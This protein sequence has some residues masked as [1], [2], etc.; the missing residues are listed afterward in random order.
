MH[1][2]IGQEAISVGV[3]AALQPEDVVFGTYRCHALYLAKGGDL[4]KMIAELYGKATGCAKGKAGSMHLIDTSAGVMGASAVV[5]TTIPLAVGHAF[6]QKLQRKP[7]VTV[8]FLG[9]GAVEEGVFHESLNFAALKKVPILFVCE[10]NSYA[11]HSR[12]RDRQARGDICALAQAHGIATER[13]EAMDVQ[14]IHARTLRTIEELRSGRSGPRFFECCCYRWRE[15]VGPGVDFQAGYRNR[16]ECESWQETDSLRTLAPLIAP[17]E[18]RRIERDIDN[19]IQSAF[20]F[21]EASP[22]PD[23]AELLTDLY[24]GDVWNG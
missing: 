8:C 15:H 23:D 4:K 14:H 5:A 9:D 13:F 18:R 12:Q 22:F 19:E 16:D 21:A 7:T 20:E 17:T 10:N 3:C 2:S 11:I 6:A 24:A 1:L